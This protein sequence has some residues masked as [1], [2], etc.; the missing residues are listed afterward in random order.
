MRALLPRVSACG[1]VSRFVVKLRACVPP[2]EISRQNG[3]G[4]MIALVCG[5]RY[6]YYAIILSS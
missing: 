4:L 1:Q 2:R 5:A 3:V 6:I